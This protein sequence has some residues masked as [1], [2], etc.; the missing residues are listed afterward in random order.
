MP[1][2][3]I[4][5]DEGTCMHGPDSS[6]PVNRVRIAAHYSKRSAPVCQK[7]RE[8][9]RCQARRVRICALLTAP[10]SRLAAAAL[11]VTRGLLNNARRTFLKCARLVGRKQTVFLAHATLFALTC[12]TL[13]ARMPGFRGL[14]GVGARRYII[15][16]HKVQGPPPMLFHW[17]PRRNADVKH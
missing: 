2:A 6:I 1:P 3:Y 16:T 5:F 15:T 17:R 14:G 9:S 11:S 8:S 10:A 13:R 7:C 12:T 4:L